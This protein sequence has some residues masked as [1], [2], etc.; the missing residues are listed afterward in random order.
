MDV[1]CTMQSQRGTPHPRMVYA[2]CIFRHDVVKMAQWQNGDLV[3]RRESLKP[4]QRIKGS[5]ARPLSSES[6]RGH[7]LSSDGSTRQ[8]RLSGGYS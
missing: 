4:A 1:T 7:A 6:G 5:R 8:N 3:S 2:V